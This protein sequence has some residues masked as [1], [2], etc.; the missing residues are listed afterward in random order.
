[1]N[2][3]AALAS[4]AMGVASLLTAASL[5]LTGDAPWSDAGPRWSAAASPSAC[6][7]LPERRG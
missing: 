3:S 1:M 4:L 5:A 2:R 7:S 6:S